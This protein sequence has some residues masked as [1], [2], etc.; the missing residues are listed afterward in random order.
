MLQ[1][2]VSFQPAHHSG[3]TYS[4]LVLDF[5]LCALSIGVAI[6]SK[7]V[8][9]LTRLW[10][11]IALLASFAGFV[12]WN[13]GVVLGISLFSLLSCHARTSFPPY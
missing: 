8:L 3:F 11:Y 10:P 5:I 12:F 7:P 4:R 1:F 9:I 13:G 6:I 2:M